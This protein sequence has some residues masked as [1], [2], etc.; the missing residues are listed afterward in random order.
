MFF[1][2]RPK[3]AKA[4]GPMIPETAWMSSSGLLFAVL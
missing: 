1:K 4:S 2:H 3:G